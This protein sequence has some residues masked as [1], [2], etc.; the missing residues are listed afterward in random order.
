MITIP[1]LNGH[2]KHDVPAPTH[3]E[4]PVSM[5]CFVDIPTM[6]RVQVTARGCT[7]AEAVTN[8]QGSVQALQA[9]VPQ[10][11]TREQQVGLLLA[12][13]ITCAVAKQDMA[14]VDR[15]SKAAYL[16]LSG[17]VEPTDTPAVMAV[18]SQTDVTTWYE[19]TTVGHTCTCPAWE[20]HR[21]AGDTA[22]ACKHGLAVA[23]FVKL[24]N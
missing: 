22:Y 10:Q 16:V 6:G 23:M 17:S 8:L 2:S 15:L 5:N 4:A 20:K 7:P 14:L 19:C 21:K 1:C 24:G 18:R 11:L 3:S 13:G 12:K 9:T